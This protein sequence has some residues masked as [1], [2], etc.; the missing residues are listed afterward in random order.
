[1]L[2]DQGFPLGRALHVLNALSVFVVGHATAEAQVV[3]G[4]QETGGTEWLA[5]LEP[6]RYPLVTRAAREAAGTDDAER[7]AFGLDAMLLGFEALRTD[8]S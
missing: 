1:M 8:S 6:G 4:A 7:F 3:V 2:T 5:A